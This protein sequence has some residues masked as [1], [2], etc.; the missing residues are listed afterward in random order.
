MQQT[1][2]TTA[3]PAETSFLTPE[4]Q[5]MLQLL[6][7]GLPLD[8]VARRMCTSSRTLRRRIR[9][10]CDRLGVQAPIQAVAWAARRHLI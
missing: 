3:R 5:R 6:A 4:E 2:S 8:S 7:D 9:A 10:V 1:A